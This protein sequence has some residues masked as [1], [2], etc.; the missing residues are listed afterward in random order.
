MEQA[1]SRRAEG[2]AETR[3]ADVRTQ[4][5][6][7]PRPGSGDGV[8]E[9]G[10]AAGATRG[11]HT[12][13]EPPIP[14]PRLKERPYGDGAPHDGR[15]PDD[16]EPPVRGQRPGARQEGPFGGV[17]ARPVVQRASVR[18][19]ILDALRTALVE[20]EL[21]PGEVYS[22]PALAERF[23][24]S[25]TPVREA[26]QQLALEGAVEVVPN[27]GFRVAVRG[28]RELAELA[29]IRA[30]IEVPVMLRL[31][32]TMPAERWAELRPLAEATVR[33]AS[34]GCRA[35]Y[36]ESDRAFHRAVLALA[37]NEQLVRI[38]EDLHRRAQWPL[39]GDPGS[40]GRADLL[41]DAAEHTA[42][43]D[44]LVAQDLA[45]VQSLVREH[46]AGAA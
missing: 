8:R 23:G 2:S 42:L 6:H 17:P 38:A 43:L 28:A 3:A 29:E 22:A 1:R 21:T 11:E 34:S 12:H 16:G 20:G 32:R 5:A 37:G 41:A 30:L 40:R 7:L 35:T 4:A 44:A 18:R 14:R 36:A 31:A 13:S 39:V 27:R 46:F 33:A 45:V 10:A 19:Q 25:A 15:R 26:M 24:V 9:R